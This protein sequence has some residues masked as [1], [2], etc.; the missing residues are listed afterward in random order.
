MVELIAFFA[1]PLGAILI[2][3]VP[4]LV[5]QIVKVAHEKGA[6]KPE[7]WLSYIQSQKSW[8]EIQP[9]K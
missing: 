9:A 6:V 2:K 4:E 5:G 7:E 8:N 1:S 3:E